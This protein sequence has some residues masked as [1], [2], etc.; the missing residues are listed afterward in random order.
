MTNK[1]VDVWQGDTL[2]S[3][4]KALYYWSLL[5]EYEKERAKIFKRQELQDKF[6]KTRAV[7]KEILAGYF[8]VTAQ[9][10]SIETAEYGKPFIKT[11][12]NIH[13]NLS[14]KG[15]KFVIAVSNVSEIG[16]DIEQYKGRQTLSGLVNKCFS[17]QEAQFWHSLPEAQQIDMFYRFWVRKEA[18]VKAVGRGI[19]LGLDQCVINPEKQSCFLSIPQVYGLASDW[20]I[21]DIKLAEEVCAVVVKN[22]IDFDFKQMQWQ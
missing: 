9:E 7:L 1:F 11:D 8:S 15:D 16:I 13:F 2:C 5:D 14:H 6:I 10:L 20:K 18:F 17:Q 4:S 22:G 19:A 12:K 21:L 3:Q